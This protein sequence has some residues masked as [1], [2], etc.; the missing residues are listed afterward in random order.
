MLEMLDT[1]VKGDEKRMQEEVNADEDLKYLMSL[2]GVLNHPTPAFD[3]R[4]YYISLII[5]ATQARHS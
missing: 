4:F 3:V 5:H 2:P 1:L